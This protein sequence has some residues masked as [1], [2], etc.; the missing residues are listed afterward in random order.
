M[1]LSSMTVSSLE[2]VIR[3]S[4]L[5]TSP[6]WSAVVVAFLVLLLSC[7]ITAFIKAARV[8][9]MDRL[10]E[11]AAAGGSRAKAL[12]SRLE[13]H[14][15]LYRELTTASVIVTATY[16]ILGAVLSVPYVA[17][18][19][20]RSDVGYRWV[21]AGVTA[22]HI[23]LFLIIGKSLPERVSGRRGGVFAVRFWYL[24]SAI[25]FVVR[26]IE[27]LAHFA[28]TALMR[29][30]RLR[31]VEAVALAPTEEEFLRMLEDGRDRGAIVEDNIELFANLFKFDDKIAS[32][33]MT[34]R[35]DIEALPVDAD[36]KSTVSFINETGYTRFPIYRGSVDNIIGV[37]HVKD[38]LFTDRDNFSL[39]KIMRKAWFTPESRVISDLFND[40]QQNH[41][42]MTIVIDEYGGT[43]GLLTIEDLVEQ[44]VGNIEDEYDEVEQEIVEI[45]PG[46]WLVA[47]SFTL[48]KLSKV[49]G[50]TFEEDDYDS[51]A[52]FLIELLDRIPEEDEQPSVRYENLVFHILSVAD[53][54]IV[55]VRVT[56]LPASGQETCEGEE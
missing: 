42:Q 19:F 7:Y 27:R 28:S 38:L 35:T 6:S 9:N 10:R 13:S 24:M 1:N 51:V 36:Y 32:D 12:L 21:Y 39:E 23:L 47:G 33:I 34:H 56:R 31:E 20:S 40:M 2:P 29:L 43:A 41:I 26:P 54:R 53:N 4:C 22:V 30:F 48:D 44:I 25:L 55:R 11:R 45:A 15:K 16:F 52:G 5:A 3:R 8:I 14:E 50:V 46:S 37:L 49:T 18:L 17:S